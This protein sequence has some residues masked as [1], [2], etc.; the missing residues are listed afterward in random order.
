MERLREGRPLRQ[1]LLLKMPLWLQSLQ[2]GYDVRLEPLRSEIVTYFPCHTVAK[3][4]GERS[5]TYDYTQC[6]SDRSTENC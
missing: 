3:M 1:E 6:S 4:V 5:T 2:L